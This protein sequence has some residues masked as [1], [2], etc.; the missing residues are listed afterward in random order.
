LSSSESELCSS[1]SGR[2]SEVEVSLL[3]GSESF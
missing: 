1:G 3:S 2:S